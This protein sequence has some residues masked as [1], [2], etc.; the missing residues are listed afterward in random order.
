LLVFVLACVLREHAVGAPLDLQIVPGLDPSAI[1]LLLFLSNVMMLGV[2]IVLDSASK[3]S[4]QLSHE[5]IEHSPVVLSVPT[6]KKTL[7]PLRTF[8]KRY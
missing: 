5:M 6:P 2:I 3:G 1:P 8:H 7:G 4:S